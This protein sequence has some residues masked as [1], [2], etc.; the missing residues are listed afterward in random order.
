MEILQYDRT[1]LSVKYRKMVP[2]GT[3]NEFQVQNPTLETI[4]SLA[5]LLDE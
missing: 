5:V 2:L 1:L 3:G 4:H